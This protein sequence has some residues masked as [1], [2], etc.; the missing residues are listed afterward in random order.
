M[1]LLAVLGL[2]SLS[3]TSQIEASQEGIRKDYV[4]RDRQLEKLWSGIYISGT[5]VRDYLLD[6]SEATAEAHKAAFLEVRRQIE[7]EAAAYERLVRPDERAVFDQFTAEFRA[8]LETVGPVLNWTASQRKAGGKSFIEKEVLPRRALVVDLADRIHELSERHLDANSDQVRKLFS[9]FRSRL[10]WL[11]VSTLGT[12]ILLTALSLRRILALELETELRFQQ[13]LTA[14]HEL[15]RLSAELISAQEDERRRISRELHDEVGQVLSAIVL[16]LGNVRSAFE[17][18]DGND[19]LRQLQ[20]VEDMTQR[21][22]NVVRNIALLLR[23]TMLDDLGLL[24]ALKWLTREVSR[25]AGI[26]IDV[27]ADGDLDDLPDE[28]RTCVYRVVQ[29]AV[30]NAGRHSGARKVKICLNR[31]STPGTNERWLLVSIQDDGK[32]FDPSQQTGLGILGM[33]ERIRR[34]GG[35]VNLDSEPGRGSIVSFELPV[36]GESPG[37]SS[38]QSLAHRV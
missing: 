10:V 29:E 34:L 19:A 1:L 2:S 14:Q 4:E 25:R 12:G 15:K 9:L 6:D 38:D 31:T 3:F 33:G 16:G 28:L 8:Y 22:V 35:V 17:R 27:T 24:P 37:V 20:L 11:L 26:D 13:L 30:N 5:Y 7:S 21:N 36:P 32:G 18:H 23:P